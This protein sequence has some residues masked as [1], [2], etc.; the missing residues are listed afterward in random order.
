MLGPRPSDGANGLPSDG[1]NGIR[2]PI[3]SKTRQLSS[4]WTTGSWERRPCGGASVLRPSGGARGRHPRS[5]EPSISLPPPPKVSI[6]KERLW[7][8]ANGLLPWGECVKLRSTYHTNNFQ[9]ENCPALIVHY[10]LTGTYCVY[11]RCCYLFLLAYKLTTYYLGFWCLLISFRICNGDKWWSSTPCV[12][13]HHCVPRKK[14]QSAQ[15][16]H[17]VQFIWDTCDYRIGSF[18]N[19]FQIKIT[20]A[21]FISILFKGL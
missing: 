8:G 11:A 9:S 4:L 14:L 15:T 16:Q 19:N 3:C 10:W 20:F 17:T 13:T 7:G 21:N 5:W 6:S 1:A 2:L 18:N 12:C